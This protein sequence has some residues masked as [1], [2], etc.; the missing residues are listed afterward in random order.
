[1]TQSRRSFLRTTTGG[2]SAIVAASLLPAGCAREYPESASD[3]VELAALSPK[4]YATARA[5]AEAILVGVPVEPGTIAARID[6]ELSIAGDPMRTDFKT[7]LDLMQHATL[8]GG[9]TRRFTALTPAQR[10]Q[11]L[12]GWARSRFA[13]RRAAF[14]ALKGFTV[15]FAYIDDRT[16]PLT[17]FEGPWPERV[18]IPAYPVDFGD[19]A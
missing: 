10:R 16:R 6:R 11:Y 1:M 9:Y 13:L 7:V 18:Q 17:R 2:A 19:V 14:Q 15:Y 5:A 4:Q 12:R 3:G 8:L